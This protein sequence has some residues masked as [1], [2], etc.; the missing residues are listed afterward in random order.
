MS[1]TPAAPDKPQ[2][3]HFVVMLIERS[4]KHFDRLASAIDGIRDDINRTM[5]WALGLVALLVIG[6]FGLYGVSL[7]VDSRLVNISAVTEEAASPPM[8][9]PPKTPRV[10]APATAPT[11][12]SYQPSE[13]ESSS[14]G[15]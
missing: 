8:M 13:P 4:D 7:R 1:E 15:G 5:R 9:R 6:M 10:A 12:P 3:D 2:A 11:A 14:N